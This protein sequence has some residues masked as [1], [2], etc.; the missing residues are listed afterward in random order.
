MLWLV[1]RLFYGSESKLVKSKPADD[2]H[3]G[4]LAILTPLVVLIV[5][6]GL[7]PSLW[8]NSIQT[9]V[10]PPALDGAV[11]LPQNVLQ[12]PVQEEGQR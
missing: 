9:G 5:V 2:A 4:E 7:A 8:T 12:I 3:F 1:Q 6:M 11:P 10:H